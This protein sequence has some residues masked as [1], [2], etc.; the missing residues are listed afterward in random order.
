MFAFDPSLAQQVKTE[1]IQQLVIPVRWEEDPKSGRLEGPVGEYLEV[2]D[3][4]PASGVVYP[5]IDLNDQYLI[6]QDGLAPSEGN[7]QF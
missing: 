5:P 2:I 3:V 1:A 7:P 6:A 4:D